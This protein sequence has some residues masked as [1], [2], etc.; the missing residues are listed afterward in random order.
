[1]FDHAA[2]R[3]RLAERMEAEGIAALFLPLSADLEYLSGVERQI[4]FFGQRSYAHGWASGGL[5]VRGADPVVVFPR[6]FVPFD[7]PEPPDG[8]LVGVKESDDG[9]ELFARA[10][11]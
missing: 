2:R 3:Q 1:M 5:F 11:S 10:M 9:D 8:E 7:L 6:M 4:P